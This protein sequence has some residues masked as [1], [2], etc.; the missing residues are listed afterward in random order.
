MPGGGSLEISTRLVQVRESS[1][2][3]ARPGDF[4]KLQVRDSGCWIEP[5]DLPQIFEPFFTTKEVGKGTGLGLATVFGIVQQHQGWITVSSQPGHG[6]CFCIFLPQPGLPLSV[7]APGRAAFSEEVG[8][9]TILVV[10]DEPSLREMLVGILR[11]QGYQV[12][13]AESGV[14]AL[15]LWEA[16]KD[17]I[18]LLLTDIVMPGGLS[19]LELGRRLLAQQPGLRVLYSTGYTDELLGE[20][21]S[22]RGTTSFLE[23]PYD[24]RKL[25]YKVR[26]CLEAA[27]Y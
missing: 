9:E 4:V 14:A 10:E 12:W 23:K 8:Q 19:G 18:Q 24:R 20:A 6:T 26:A 11:S 2:Q 1:S 15:P 16:H 17:S 5:E 22:L 25:L 27:D 13:A 3:G 7:A 21:S